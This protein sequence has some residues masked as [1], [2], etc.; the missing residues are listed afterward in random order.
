M[1]ASPDNR[2]SDILF[3]RYDLIL[4]KLEN[5][6]SASAELPSYKQNLYV[7][8]FVLVGIFYTLDKISQ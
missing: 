7:Q 1:S 6:H 3:L 8:I 4:R 2:P 5:E